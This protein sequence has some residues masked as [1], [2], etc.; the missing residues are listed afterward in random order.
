MFTINRTDYDSTKWYW[1]KGT[2]VMDRTGYETEQEAN[3][4]ITLIVANG[5]HYGDPLE[6]R[7][8]GQL[9]SAY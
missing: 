1:T 9:I 8:D 7:H 4:Q 6:L 2:W 3:L 5:W